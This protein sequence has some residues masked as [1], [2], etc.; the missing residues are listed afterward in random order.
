MCD[1][2]AVKMCPRCDADDER[3]ERDDDETTREPEPQ[4]VAEWHAQT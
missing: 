4:E 2:T 1:C 3:R